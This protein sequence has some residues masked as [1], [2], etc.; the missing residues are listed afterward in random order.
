MI[1]FLWLLK[2]VKPFEKFT[3]EA[4]GKLSHA[5]LIVHPDGENLLTY[6]KIFA[7]TAIRADER[8]AKL[9]ENDLHP[10][11]KIYPAD[12]D[13]VLTE[14]VADLISESY[15]KPI[16]SDKKVFI[17]NHAETMNLT[18]QN[19]LL[20]TL[21][22][23]P[24]NVVILLGA[25]SEYPLIATV[26]SR[27]RKFFIP[28]FDKADLFTALKDDCPDS[29][30]LEVAIACG[31]GT[32]GKAYKYYHDEKFGDTV[33]AVIDLIINMKSSKNVLTFSRKIVGKYD[34]NDF[35]NV[36]KTIFRDMLAGAENRENLVFDLPAYEKVKNAEG[37]TEG[38][39][40][41]A[42]EKIKEAEERLKFNSSEEMVVEW[43]MFQILE[44]KYKWRKL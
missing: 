36:L 5:Y 12:R 29:G 17:I 40:V 35:L 19:K 23:P 18:A 31:D 16:E 22:E 1:D 24:K 41:Y 21:E 11:V 9:V 44:G 42:I 38:A 4:D 28:E 13:A 30:K 3:A 32:V 14:D 27:V 8:A 15:I 33:D 2:K 37:F 26:K 39:I 43:L 34:V 6:L 7:K 25:T 10:D 20:K